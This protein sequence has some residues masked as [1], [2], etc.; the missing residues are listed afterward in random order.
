MEFDSEDELPDSDDPGAGTWLMIV[1]CVAVVA[2]AVALTMDGLAGHIFG[3]L[4][5][6]VLTFTCV[7]LFR[8]HALDRLATVGIGTSRRASGF[9]LVVLLSGL[10]VSIAHAWFIARRYA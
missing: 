4:L 7:A 5:A 3:Y 8:R 1:A 6:S 9:V 10:G 2:G